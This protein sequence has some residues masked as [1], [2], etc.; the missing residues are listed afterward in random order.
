M[1]LLAETP[2]QWPRLLRDFKASLLTSLQSPRH[3]TINAAPPQGDLNNDGFTFNDRMDNLPRN[4][5]LGDSYYDVDVRLQRE[6][7]FTERVKGIASFEVFNLFNRA[8][9]EEIDHLYVTPSPVGSFVDPLGNPVPVPQRFG[10]HISDGNGGFGAP[11]FVAPARQIQ[12]SFRI[13]F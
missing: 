4:S 5:Y 11:K 3:F 10:D 13:N 9:V 7:P 6:I 8:N 12:L 2:Q 1:A